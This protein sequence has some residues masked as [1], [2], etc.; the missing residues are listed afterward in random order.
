MLNKI[1]KLILNSKIKYA[2]ISKTNYT[3]D[4]T[5][6]GQPTFKED[7][8]T[9]G[10]DFAQVGAFALSFDANNQTMAKA[11]KLSITSG[12]VEKVRKMAGV[13]LNQA[14]AQTIGNASANTIRKA[15]AFAICKNS[16][17]HYKPLIKTKDTKLYAEKCGV[18]CWSTILQ[19]YFE[20]LTDFGKNSILE[21]VG[22]GVEILT[23]N[24]VANLVERMT[25]QNEN[26]KK[27]KAQAKANDKAK[28]TAQA[29]AQAEK[30]A[31]QGKKKPSTSKA[32]A[33]A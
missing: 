15:I 3:Q 31:T 5:K 27:T 21:K 11:K 14:T 2:E 33:K 29:Q 25:K 17:T 1:E 26:D 16:H 32:K 8:K 7:Y 10:K 22:G 9:T 4:Q 30:Q 20:I 28:K 13:I 6:E 24:K 18:A 12:L 23:P 19:T